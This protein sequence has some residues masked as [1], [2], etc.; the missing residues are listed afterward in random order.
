MF[1]SLDEVA[2][3][4]SYVRTLDYQDKPD[5][6]HLKEI[7]AS[8]VRGRLDFSMPQGPVGESATKVADPHTGEKVRAQ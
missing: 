7:L 2:E 1:L 6:Q 4:L 5:Y 8:V 3:F